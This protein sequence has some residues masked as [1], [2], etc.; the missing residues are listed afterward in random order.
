VILTDAERQGAL[1]HL[2]KATGS[3]VVGVVDRPSWGIR[4]QDGRVV[5]LGSDVVIQPIPPDR[6]ERLLR[7]LGRSG[8]FSDRTVR[9]FVMAVETLIADQNASRE[10]RSAHDRT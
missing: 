3:T 5:L 2:S 1:D 4:T 7:P 6:L 9:R 8:R 10:G